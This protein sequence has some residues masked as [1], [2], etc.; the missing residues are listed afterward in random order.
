MP[1]SLPKNTRPANTVGWAVTA[2]TPGMPNAHFNVSRGT[3]S[4]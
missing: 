3:D 2:L 1:I 4:R